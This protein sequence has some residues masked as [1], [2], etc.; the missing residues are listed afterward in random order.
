MSLINLASRVTLLYSRA[1]IGLAFTAFAAAGLSQTFAAGPVLAPGSVFAANEEGGSLSRIDLQSGAAQSIKLPV[2]PHN[3]DLSAEARLV[4]VVGLVP[5]AGD[6]MST[7]MKMSTGGESAPATESEE[8]AGRLV[9]FLA[10]STA[11]LEPHGFRTSPYFVPDA[12]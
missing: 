3:V 8:P 10:A 7:T 6:G 5:K 11:E 9:I 2:M 1:F 4:F 12:V